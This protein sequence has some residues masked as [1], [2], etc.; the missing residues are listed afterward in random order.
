MEVQKEDFQ[1]SNDIL[2]QAQR[3]DLKAFLWQNKDVFTVSLKNL[4]HYRKKEMQIDLIDSNPVHTNYYRT[5]E[6]LQKMIDEHVDKLLEHDIIEPCLSPYASP[7]CLVKKKQISPKKGMA[8]YRLVV[9][10][11]KCNQKIKDISFPIP[12]IQGLFTDIGSQQPTVFTVC[13]LSSAFYQLR[14]RKQDRPI[15]AFATKTGSYQ[16][17]RVPFGMKGSPIFFTSVMTNLLQKIH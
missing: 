16:W 6:K 12:K 3:E 14:I 2:T 10:Y 15:T 7:C 5:T 8:V 11:R 1:V 4:G 13:D 9:D 17:K